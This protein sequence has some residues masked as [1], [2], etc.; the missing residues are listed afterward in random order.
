M[1]LYLKSKKYT[2]FCAELCQEIARRRVF[3][4]SST[5]SPLFSESRSRVAPLCCRCCCRWCSDT[6]TKA[7]AVNLS[8]VG[9]NHKS[10][11]LLGGT[12]EKGTQLFRVFDCSQNTKTQKVLL[13]PPPPKKT[14]KKR[15]RKRSEK[16]SFLKQHHPPKAPLG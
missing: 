6:W 5:V 1:F 12:Q 13:R 9:K 15:S 10:L 16:S 14:K 11:L 4:S 8:L 3:F 7:L 2:R